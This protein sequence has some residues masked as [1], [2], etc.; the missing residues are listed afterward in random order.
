[1]VEGWQSNSERETGA[2]QE[3]GKG[4]AEGQ[5]RASKDEAGGVW[6]LRWNL[7]AWL[8]ASKGTPYK[9]WSSIL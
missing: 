8:I 5:H 9:G 3:G 4:E 2:W 6:G 1:M 7:P